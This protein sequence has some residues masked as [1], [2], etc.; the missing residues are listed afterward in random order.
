MRRF[1]P[2]FQLEDR[3]V[4]RMAIAF[5]V[6]LLAAAVSV[7]AQQPRT[8][9]RGRELIPEDM[10]ATRTDGESLDSLSASPEIYFYQS[11][12]RRHDDPKHS[13]RRKADFRAFQRQRRLAA[14]KWFGISNSRPTAN[15]TPLTSSYA[16]GWAASPLQPYRWTG[17]TGPAT[18][19]VTRRSA[20]GLW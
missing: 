10:P 9:V 4:N 13:I 2:H 1:L 14:L 8:I 3:A 15:P 20:F 11:E 5:A 18:V 16:H 17:T 12:L 6:P 19:L 7:L